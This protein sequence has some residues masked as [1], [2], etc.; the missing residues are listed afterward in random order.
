MSST[1]T[2]VLTSDPNG[3]YN[4][5]YCNLFST[6]NGF[7]T[8]DNCTYDYNGPSTINKTSFQ[9]GELKCL[10]NCNKNPYCTSYSYDTNAPTNTNNCTEYS[11]FPSLI[12][13]NAS[14]INSGY[15]LKFPFDY[16][17]LSGPPSSLDTQ[18]NI[19][20]NKCI[21]QYLNNQFTPTKQIDIKNCLTI[22]TTNDVTNITADPQ[23][24]YNTYTAN[25][26]Q[27][28]VI[29]NS[30]YNNTN[31]LSLE[32]QTDP[33]IDTYEESYNSYLSNI[34]NISSNNSN[35]TVT[36]NN[37]SYGNFISEE[38]NNLFN[39]YTNSINQKESD[40]NILLN[41]VIKE[42]FENEIT[43]I[44]YETYIKLIVFFIIIVFI[45][46]MIYI[47]FKKK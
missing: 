38:N 17:K 29:N 23:C 46:F 9:E 15:S 27:T 7:S 31:N 32:S 45:I 19:I 34:A 35:Q 40:I 26:E 16:T 22:N 5:I 25:G 36:N 28:T 41:N 39:D 4:Q 33:I 21:S 47:T 12:N 3:L 24:V 18:Q 30:T 44:S 11:T 10:N 37:I 43:N 8:C 42:S 20:Q 13:T 2:P 14:G 1:S 6:T